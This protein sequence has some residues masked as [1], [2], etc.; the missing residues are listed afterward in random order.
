MAIFI[1][2]LPLESPWTWW[3]SSSLRQRLPGRVFPSPIAM[4]DS[5]MAHG[6]WILGP[7]VS[8]DLGIWAA[9]VLQTASRFR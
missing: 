5:P 2:D 6:C 1:V 8:F 9:M 7:P 3:V 4:L